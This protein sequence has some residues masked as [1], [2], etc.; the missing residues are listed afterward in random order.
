MAMGPTGLS[1]DPI[2]TGSYCYT[3]LSPMEV[4]PEGGLPRM[5]IKACP[6]W[7]RAPQGSYAAYCEYLDVTDDILLWDQVKICDVRDDWDDEFAL[8][9]IEEIFTKK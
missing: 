8:N 9:P 4:P 5:L 6:Y 3:R 7:N 1:D 2:P